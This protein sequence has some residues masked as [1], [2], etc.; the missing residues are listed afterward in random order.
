MA[1]R[2]AGST[3]TYFVS[4]KA[5]INAPADRVY[6][7]IADYRNGHPHILPKQFGPL[8]VDAGGYGAG[9]VIRFSVVVMGRKTDFRAI[10]SEPQPGRVLVERNDPPNNSVSTFTVDACAPGECDVTIATEMPR[11]PGFF[12]A[13]EKFVATRVMNGMY[14]DELKLLAA[15]A[16]K[17]G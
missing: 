2:V 10:V 15:F 4:A 7:I 14:R 11:R 17:R 1:D 3:A 13:F 6:G 8:L 9:T 5:R 12:G 16:V